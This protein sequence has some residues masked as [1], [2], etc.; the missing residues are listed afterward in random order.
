MKTYN[1]YKLFV[2]SFIP[3]WLMSRSEISPGA[4]LC[5]ARLAQYA[6][7]DGK[8]YPAQTTLAKELGVSES[9]AK[10]YVKELVKH[11]LINSIRHGLNKSNSYQF[12]HHEWMEDKPTIKNKRGVIS[13]LSGSVISDLSGSVISG[14]SDSSHMTPQEGA[15]L[16]YKENQLRESKKREREPP[17]S[18]FEKKEIQNE[19]P[20][21]AMANIL[22]I[23]G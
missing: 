8:C 7:E 21:K 12:L 16:T 22:K 15:D 13:D 19:N 4:K 1:P 18:V 17:V 20:K 23:V 6:G 5:F 3:N 10:R 9:Q 11:R 2:G 14:R